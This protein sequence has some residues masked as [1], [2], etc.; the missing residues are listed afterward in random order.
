MG[1][2]LPTLCIASFSSS[3]SFFSSFFSSSSLHLPPPPPS[4]AM[5]H[6][7]PGGSLWIFPIT[8]RNTF[9]FMI[10]CLYLKDTW[11]PKVFSVLTEATLTPVC[12]LQINCSWRPL[13][14]TLLLA[15]RHFSFIAKF[16]VCFSVTCETGL[17][18]FFFPLKSKMSAVFKVA[19]CRQ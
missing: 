2:A 7:S 4:A 10:S 11:F 13:Y 6:V 19:E 3:P 16:A 15:T 14:L 5:L 17:F 9:T 12:V 18:F 8:V 1:I